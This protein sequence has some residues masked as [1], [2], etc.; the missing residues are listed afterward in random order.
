MLGMVGGKKA[1][2]PTEKDPVKK[3]LKMEKLMMFQ[4]G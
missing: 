2:E 4:I 1:L 3:K